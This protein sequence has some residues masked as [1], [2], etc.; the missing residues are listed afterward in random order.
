MLLFR[1]L[2][3]ISSVFQLSVTLMSALML[4]GKL[5]A[6]Y[7][8]CVLLVLNFQGRTLLH[9]EGDN[10]EHAE[11]VKNTLIFN[12]FVLCQVNFNF[13]LFEYDEL[14]KYFWV[15]IYSFKAISPLPKG[16]IAR[17]LEISNRYTYTHGQF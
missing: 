9:L 6:L 5:Q 1:N 15:Y 17:L 13:S 10:K 2:H 16:P 7:Q 11:K 12:A 3:V 8:V 4:V 14:L